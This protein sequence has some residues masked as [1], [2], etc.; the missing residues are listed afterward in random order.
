MNN[1][2]FLLLFLVGI[3]MSSCEQETFEESTTQADL[4]FNTEASIL[5]SNERSVTDPVV[6]ENHL[7]WL[8]L[9][10]VIY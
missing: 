4:Q 5:N 1:L 2:K 7:Q 9:L 3:F 8:S 10:L 6:F